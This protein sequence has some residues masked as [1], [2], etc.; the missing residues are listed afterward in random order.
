MSTKYSPQIVSDSSLVLYLDA[1]NVKS[2]SS[3][4]TTWNDLGG[5]YNGTLTNGPTFNTSNGGSIV[6]DGSNDYVSIASNANILSTTNYTKTVW[7]YIS[8]FAT[9]N[10]IVSGGNTG[11]HAFWMF[12]SNKLNA[13]H[14]GAWN[15]VVS[16]T[17]LL[18]NTWYYGAVTFNTTTGWNL[19][20]N[21]K[22]EAT[23][24]NTTTFNGNGDISLG[25]YLGA[26]NYLTGRIS[27]AL[28]YNRVLSAS[29][30][31]NNYNALKGRF[32]L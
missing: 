11:Q 13:G 22:L 32:G 2:Y 14:N 4:S 18:V 16:T 30:I 31:L 6:F 23:S 26:G 15:T 3:G 8:N 20:L 21:S 29:E 27:N 25:S 5:R 9:D 10:N 19:Y 7:F 28:I 24:S 1:A 17:T 12:T